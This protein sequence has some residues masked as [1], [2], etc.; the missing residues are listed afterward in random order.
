[1]EKYH[2]GSAVDL[3]VEFKEPIADDPF[4]EDEYTDPTA[5]AV[6]VIDPESTKMLS[7]ISLVRSDTGM[8]YYRCQTLITWVAGIYQVK[9]NATSGAY[10][11]VT[12]NESCFELV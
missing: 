7:A 6:T 8:W 10:S 2:R 1:M 9:V 3:K 11:D 12:I 4:N 5:P